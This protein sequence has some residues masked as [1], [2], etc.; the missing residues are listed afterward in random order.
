MPRGPRLIQDV[1]VLRPTIDPKGD[2]VVP[3]S[4]TVVR[5]TVWT[6]RAKPIAAGTGEVLEVT[7]IGFLAS[8]TDVQRRDRLR[9]ASGQTGGP[10]LFQVAHVVRAYDD[11]GR[12]SHVGVELQD[13]PEG[14][15]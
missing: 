6:R 15:H 13:P 1:E 3:V 2:A 5:G 12:E 10:A 14:P 8:G 4:G 7:G 9:L 11:R